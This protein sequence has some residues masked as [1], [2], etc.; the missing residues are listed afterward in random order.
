MSGDLD[1]ILND[2]KQPVQEIETPE[3][4]ETPTEPEAT[5]E[6]VAE[7][8]KGPVRD[9]KGRFAPKGETESASPAPVNEP[10]LDHAAVLGER[11]RRQEAEARIRELEQRMAQFQQP[12]YQPTAHPAPQAAP[13][14]EFNEDLYWSN[15][16]Q[17][18][19]GFA[20]NIRQSVMQEVQ[21]IIPQMVTGVSIDRAE[22]AARARYED[23]D[24]AI[25][26]FREVALVTHSVRE[27]M[28]VQADPAEFAYQECKRLL[29]MSN[30]GS[31]NEYIEAEVAR[32]LA[33]I[34]QVAK[35]API[36]PVSLADAPASG[37]SG[38][39]PTAPPSLDAI[40][41]RKG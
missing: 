4:P 31:T 25:A 16:Q 22:Q 11:R 29:E 9:E 30:Y 24:Q 18:L 20:Q 32:R 10:P 36:I 15:P 34:Q 3:V 19:D 41:T 37:P 40:L 8:P 38:T 12:T 35:P 1:S 13:S 26:A 28:A 39:V 27:K 17:F 6:P 5:P 2:D 33:A 21:G 7:E 14:F 23:Y